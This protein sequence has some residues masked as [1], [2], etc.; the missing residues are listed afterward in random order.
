LIYR[1]Y[2]LSLHL[3]SGDPVDII[4][5]NGIESDQCG[6]AVENIKM[7][8]G[9]LDGMFLKNAACLSHFVLFDV[10]NP[11]ESRLHL[12]PD[13]ASIGL[14]LNVCRRTSPKCI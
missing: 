1:K 13:S 8:A 11:L 9:G 3:L 10:I 7:N 6:L 12:N 5:F 2:T 14:Y 4:I